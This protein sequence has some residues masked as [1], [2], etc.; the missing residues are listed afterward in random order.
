MLRRVSFELG[1]FA[2][3]TTSRLLGVLELFVLE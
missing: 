2:L 3:P 1:H